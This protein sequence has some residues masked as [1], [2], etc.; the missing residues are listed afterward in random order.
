[1]ANLF[2]VRMRMTLQQL[3]CHQD[4][5][6]RAEPALKAALGEERLLNRMKDSL[7]R[8]SFNGD[9][10]SSVDERGEVEAAGYGGSVH[11]QG[12]APAQSLPAALPR[13]EETEVALKYF[14]DRFVRCDRRRNC[15]AIQRETNHSVWCGAHQ[16]GSSGRFSIL[17]IARSTRSGVSGRSVTTTPMASYRAL[18]IAGDGLKIPVS[19]TPFAPYG[20]LLCGTST[21]AALRSRGTSRSPGIL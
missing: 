19:P 10:I 2:V 11:D 13:T 14:E 9:D 21:M 7:V 5:S 18:A 6:G 4:E 17:R 3:F 20:P 8:E 12:A 15:A 16:S 1:M